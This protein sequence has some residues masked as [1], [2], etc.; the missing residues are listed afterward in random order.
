MSPIGLTISIK[1]QQQ[2]DAF[3]GSFFTDI[4]GRTSGRTTMHREL[5]SVGVFFRALNNSRMLGFPHDLSKSERPD[6]IVNDPEHGRYGLEVSEVI[7][8]RE[9][10][11]YERGEV[12]TKATLLNKSGWRGDAPERACARSIL[13]RLGRK[14]SKI[15]RYPFVQK[16]VLEIDLLLYLNKET[17]FFSRDKRII[18]LLQTSNRHEAGKLGLRKVHIIKGS[19]LLFDVFGRAEILN[20]QTEA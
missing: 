10:E 7:S 19:K 16:Q 14:R 9:A 1:N 12:R 4:P 2:A 15:S 6:F 20:T 3:W 11:S 13:Y 17:A 5:Y 8:S 18:D